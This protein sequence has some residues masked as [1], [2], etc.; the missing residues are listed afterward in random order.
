MSIGIYRVILPHESE[1]PEPITFVMGAPLAVGERYTGPEG[2]D[3]WYFCTTPGQQGG[4]VPVQIIEGLASEAPFAREDYT[5]R[6][7]DVRKGDTLLG[8]RILNGWLW[9]RPVE[10]TEHGWVPLANLQ[11]VA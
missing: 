3:D 11:E 8:L 10:G 7:L 2:W 6:E 9:C 4:W 5:A 1:Y